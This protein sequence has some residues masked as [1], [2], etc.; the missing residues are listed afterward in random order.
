M[1]IALFTERL[2]L[3]FGVDLVVHEQA[4]R[5]SKNHEVVVFAIE[6]D[7]AFIS[8]ASYAIYPLH[9]PLSFNPIKQ[10]LN[11]Y[12]WY[13]VYEHLFDSFDVYIIHTPTFN[14]WIPRLS[15]KAPLFV[16]YYGNSPSYGYPFPKNYRK[17]I[18][19]FTENN[20]YFNYA[21][22]VFTI[23]EY[24]KKQLPM[25]IQ[26][27]TQVLYLGTE[28]ITHRKKY[29]AVKEMKKFKR[30]YFIRNN[31][32]LITY[33][34][35]L[36]Y[37]NNPYKNTKELLKVHDYVKEKYGSSIKIFALGIPENNIEKRFFKRGLNIIPNAPTEDLI[38][39]LRLSYMYISP[40]KWEGFNLPLVEAQS[41]GTPVV[42]Y[43]VAAHPEVV[44]DG[45]TG[46]L[47]RSER[48]MMD[49]I[50]YLLN[51]PKIRKKMSDECLIFAKTF[52]WEKNVEILESALQDHTQ[53]SKSN[54]ENDFHRNG[55]V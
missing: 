1:K 11:S 21:T 46:F 54:A 53:T 41:V 33:V 6:T 19:D 43:K 36:D 13:S 42:C 47:A 12:M 29:D 40:S 27:K 35:R 25:K 22:K 5:L 48:Q 4:K 8:D 14:A 37:K 52:S 2:K 28:H 50:K 55:D 7:Q 26:K 18:M 44:K 38:S 24:L 49:N 10:D 20:F 23:S 17:S 3:G 51:N 31:E 45:K 39:A 16:Y 34:G 30:K 15:K 9:I 32:R